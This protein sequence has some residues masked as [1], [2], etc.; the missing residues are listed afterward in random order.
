MKTKSQIIDEFKKKFTCGG[1]CFD[2]EATLI[3]LSETLDEVVEGIPP[4]Y[5]SGVHQY[6]NDFKS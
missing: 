5:S 3:W 2:S 1:K 4:N 6:I